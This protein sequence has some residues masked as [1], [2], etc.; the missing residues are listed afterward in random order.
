MLKLKQFIFEN[1]TAIQFLKQQTKDKELINSYK[2]DVKSFLADKEVNFTNT[3]SNSDVKLISWFTK[4]LYVQ[5]IKPEIVEAVLSNWWENIGDWIVSNLPNNQIQSKLALKEFDYPK[6]VEES[7]KWH[8]SL[9]SQENKEGAVG[10]IALPLNDVPGFAGWNWV[11]LDK[12]YCEKEGKVMG[13]CGNSAG[14][15]TDNIFSLRD[16]KNIPHLTFII[17]YGVL[18][19]SKGRG[20]SKPAKKYHPA[21]IKL[22]LSDQIE[23]IAGGGYMPENNFQL[24]D[25]APEE[26]ELIKSK[27]PYILKPE[28]FIAKRNQTFDIELNKKI[29]N[30]LLNANTPEK[31]EKTLKDLLNGQINFNMWGMKNILPPRVKPKKKPK[32]EPGITDDDDW[33]Y[34]TRPQNLNNN[35][36]PEISSSNAPT[37]GNIPPMMEPLSALKLLLDVAYTSSRKIKDPELFFQWMDK[38]IETA[39]SEYMQNDIAKLNFY[40]KQ[41]GNMVGVHMI[42]NIGKIDDF[43]MNLYKQQPDIMRAAPKRNRFSSFRKYLDNLAEFLDSYGYDLPDFRPGSNMISYE[44]L[45]KAGQELAKQG[46]SVIELAKEIE[47]RKP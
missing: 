28:Q 14:K 10:R 36:P 27:K 40:S 39:I 47:A 18:G 32:K 19:E 22:L 11:A 44:F 26:Q 29:T 33:Y 2:E 13:H 8:E 38:M 5:K 46:K 21:I 12:K 3:P 4:E 41:P 35:E 25:L 37:Y 9:T 17:N 6:A 16:P 34:D 30:T 1:M 42:L 45:V 15:P 24:S 31:I 20:N 7:Q 43:I 23:A